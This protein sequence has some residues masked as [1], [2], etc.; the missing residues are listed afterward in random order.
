V[1]AFRANGAVAV[2]VMPVPPF[3]EAHITMSMTPVAVPPAITFRHRHA[4][5][6]ATM[7]RAMHPPF[8]ALGLTPAPRDVRSRRI[9]V[10]IGG[11]S[12]LV[13]NSSSRAAGT[14]ATRTGAAA[15]GYCMH[16]HQ[17]GAGHQ[18]NSKQ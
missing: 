2:A 8:A 13:G 15:L 12:G 18:Q 1:V 14:G 10:P 6:A 5:F 9:R 4:G 11:A 7:C 16:W 17:Q 3:L